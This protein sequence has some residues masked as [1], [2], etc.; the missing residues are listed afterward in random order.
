LIFGKKII[1]TK[2]YNFQKLPYHKIFYGHKTFF[3]QTIL[4]KW[5]LDIFQKSKMS[6]FFG[7]FPFHQN[8]QK[9]E[10]F[11][12]FLFHLFH[13]PK[14]VV[15]TKYLLPLY[16]L[17]VIGEKVR[18]TFFHQKC[19]IVFHFLKNFYKTW[20]L[21]KKLSSQNFST[22]KNCLTIK[23]FMV[24]KHF[25]RKLFWE[26][27]NWTFLNF[28]KCPTFL[29]TFHFTDNICIFLIAR[30]YFPFSFFLFIKVY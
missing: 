11:A 8:M 2:F 5:K 19:F 25:L 7:N 15:F 4:G 29:V 22:S 17:V 30:L 9:C 27:E 24:T 26:N 3:A 10:T 28:E 21:E 23:F 18:A 20:F 1:V 14:I 13:L 6:N 12:T 16:D